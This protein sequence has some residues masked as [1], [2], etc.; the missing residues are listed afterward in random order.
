MLL[1]EREREERKGRRK[2]EIGKRSVSPLLELQ[3]IS[4]YHRALISPHLIRGNGR[5]VAR[6]VQCQGWEVQ[7]RLVR[8]ARL[9]RGDVG[10]LNGVVLGSVHAPL[11]FF[12]SLL[13]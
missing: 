4:V 12:L 6:K 11:N 8:Y 10:V 2:S 5:D 1:R 3:L 7:V 9:C 13:V